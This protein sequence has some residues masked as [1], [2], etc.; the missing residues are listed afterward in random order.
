MLANSSF[1]DARVIVFA[2]YASTQWVKV[3][4]YPVARR[5]LS[6]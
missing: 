5:L 4:E 2:K 3:G 6:Q 1:V